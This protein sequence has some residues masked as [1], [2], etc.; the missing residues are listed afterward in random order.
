MTFAEFETQFR[1]LLT[2][3]TTALMGQIKLTAIERDELRLSWRAL[4][5]ADRARALDLLRGQSVDV[6][7]WS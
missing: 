4:G 6:R 5:E 2:N 1:E 7:G 3:D